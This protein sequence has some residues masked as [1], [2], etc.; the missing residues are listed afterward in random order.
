MNDSDS[1]SGWRRVLLKAFGFGAGFAL[2]GIMAVSAWVWYSDRPKPPQPWN[3]HAVTATYEFVTT[4]KEKNHVVFVYTLENKTKEDYRL[5]DKSEVDIFHRL[6]SEK[7]IFR[8]GEQPQ[9]HFPLFVPASG[10]TTV[11]IEDHLEYSGPK[12]SDD[13]SGKEFRAD[14]QE[15]VKAKHGNLGGFVL[16]DQIH[17]YQIEF[18]KGW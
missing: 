12:S 7:S 8:S 15:F 9:I 4:D 11:S 10:R 3:T 2:V 13:D 17:R 5:R 18:P 16:F 1:L 6:L 14:V